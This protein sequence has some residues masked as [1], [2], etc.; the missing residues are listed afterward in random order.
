[1]GRYDEIEEF[2]GAILSEEADKVLGAWGTLDAEERHDVERHLRRMSD[3]LEGY[4]EV[5][6]QSARAAL[7]IIRGEG[8]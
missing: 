3:P 1:M 2:W 8:N 6:Q 7:A 5:Q 4:A